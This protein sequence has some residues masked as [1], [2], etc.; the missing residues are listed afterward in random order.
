MDLNIRGSRLRAKNRQP[1]VQNVNNGKFPCPRPG[2]WDADAHGTTFE[3]RRALLVMRFSDPNNTFQP[4][5]LLD[6][7]VIGGIH[8]AAGPGELSMEMYG[9]I[10]GAQRS[11]QEIIA[12]IHT[13]PISG[14]ESIRCVDIIGGEPEFEH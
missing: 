3:P 9:V 13:R 6:R 2:P 8:S 5:Q 1:A 12:I 11:Q 4:Q 7:Q 10:S 14:F